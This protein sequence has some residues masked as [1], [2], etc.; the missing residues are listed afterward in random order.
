MKASRL[1]RIIH[2]WGSICTAIPV[3]VVLVTGVTLQLKKQS[4]W[5]QPTTQRGADQPPQ[6]S[7]P[8]ILAATRSVREA[9]VESWDDIDRLDVRPSKGMLKV[10]CKNCWEIQLDA[11]SGD[12]L[13]VAYRRSDLIESLHDGSYF[14]DWVKMGVFLPSAIILVVLWGSGV[15]LFFLPH[16]SK[17]R[18]RL[19]HNTKADA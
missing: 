14:S 12:V 8:E 18:K 17:R 6:I 2:R 7:F 16:L 1:N 19:Q 15:Y 3:L 10:R 5:I 13:Q 4:T 9:E 11:S